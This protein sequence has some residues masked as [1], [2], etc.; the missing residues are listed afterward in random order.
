M[1]RPRKDPWGL[2]PR[3]RPW[4][5]LGSL[6]DLCGRFRPVGP[7][8]S[9]FDAYVG[10]VCHCHCGSDRR[11]RHPVHLVLVNG[12][13][14]CRTITTRT[15]DLILDSILAFTGTYSIIPVFLWDCTGQPNPQIG[16]R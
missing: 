4:E 13:F 2:S 3:L 7:P 10:R 12:S 5:A 15:R 9:S 11:S 8:R 1:V 16:L 14:G 6:M